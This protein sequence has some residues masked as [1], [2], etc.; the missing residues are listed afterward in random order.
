MIQLNI[1]QLETGDNCIIV[2][3]NVLVGKKSSFNSRK[4]LF[5][6]QDCVSLARF[7]LFN[8]FVSFLL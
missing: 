2:I 3:G 7:N 4:F 1:C 6:L 5:P 8:L